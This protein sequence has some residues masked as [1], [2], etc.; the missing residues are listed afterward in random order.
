MF[1]AV[2]CVL[3]LFAV[4]ISAYDFKDADFNEYLFD[5]LQADY[6]E[7]FDTIVRLRRDTE[8]TETSTPAKESKE[9]GKRDWKKD[10]LCCTGDKF[11]MKHFEVF[12][13]A[14]KQCYA[15]VRGNNSDDSFDPFDCQKMQQVKEQV[16][17]VSE[18]V[19]KKLNIVD[20][21]GALN[22]DVL[23]TH[24]K[25]KIGDSQWKKDVL[26]SYVDKCAGEAKEKTVKNSSEEVN[27]CNSQPMTFHHC[28]WREFT[29]GCPVELR[30]DSPKC[31]KIR[32]RLAKGDTSFLNK[33]F[34]HHYHHGRH[35]EQVQ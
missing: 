3:Y 34:L 35:E 20:E 16:V 23:L 6:E 12:K 24:L 15:E 14:K 19:A 26:E 21:T 13:E 29:N 5:E 2:V 10:G 30:V 33:H 32:V 4:T 11:D 7:G 31:S 9:C 1:K 28:L 17:C 8:V 22:R 25:S 18:C 27:K